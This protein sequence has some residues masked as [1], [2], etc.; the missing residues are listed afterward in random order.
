MNSWDKKILTIKEYENM[1]KEYDKCKI[2]CSR[3]GHKT[4]IPVWVD[5]L[6]C[7]WCGYYIYRNKQLEFKEKVKQLMKVR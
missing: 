6:P 4:I 1:T 7:N 2:K 3:C 5:K